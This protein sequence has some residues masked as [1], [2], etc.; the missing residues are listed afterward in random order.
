M[1]VTL[2]VI[3]T[4]AVGAALGHRAA[5]AEYD[6]LFYGRN[7]E[8]LQR[9]LA[10]CG[11]RARSASLPTM[12]QS[13]DLLLIAIP[14]AAVAETLKKAGPLSNKTI[15]DATNPLSPDHRSLMIGHSTSGAEEIAALFPEAH[16]VKAFNATFAEIY[17]SEESSITGRTVSIFYAGNYSPAKKRVRELILRI[18]FDAVD[19]GPLSS[20]R[21]LEPMSMMNILLGRVLGMGPYIGYRLLREEREKPLDLSFSN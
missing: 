12:A 9:A 2:G 19:T 4:G 3:G 17:A 5:K 8:K 14:Y 15:I 16:I 18:G 7:S 13:A 11:P 21:Y 6:V 1:S 10:L 20:A